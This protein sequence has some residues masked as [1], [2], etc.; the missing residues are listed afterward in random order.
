[1]YYYVV[2]S[3]LNH[4]SFSVGNLVVS[5]NLNHHRMT[6]FPHHNLINFQFLAAC[7]QISSTLKLIPVA[8]SS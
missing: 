6:F 5:R 7:P 8:L 4:E 3:S 1:M 2:C